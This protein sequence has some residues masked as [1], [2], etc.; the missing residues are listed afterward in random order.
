M[1]WAELAMAYPPA[2]IA[3][4]EIRDRKVS[5]ILSGAGNRDLFHDVVSINAYAFSDQATYDLFIALRQSSPAVA[6]EY[7][8]LALPAIVLCQ[9]FQLAR[10]YMP[11]PGPEVKMLS[12]CLNRDVAELKDVPPSPAPRLTAYIS[13]YVKEVKLFVAI[14]RGVGEEE[15]ADQLQRLASELIETEEVRAAIL[16]GL[17]CAEPIRGR[18]PK[19]GQ[20]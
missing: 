8:S 6:A 19:F 3:L 10:L 18:V 12:E 2:R 5:E 13:N 16:S 17:M 9:D 14:L 11:D 4:R 1:Y 20:N 7:A 15:T